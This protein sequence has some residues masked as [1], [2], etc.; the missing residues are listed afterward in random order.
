MDN[1]D[2]GTSSLCKVQAGGG[3]HLQELKPRSPFILNKELFINTEGERVLVVALTIASRIVIFF[4]SALSLDLCSALVFEAN[5]LITYLFFATPCLKPDETGFV[6]DC[7]RFNFRTFECV[8]LAKVLSEFDSVRLQ[9][10]R[11]TSYSG[12]S[13]Q[14]PGEV[15]LRNMERVGIIISKYERLSALLNK[16]R[17]LWCRRGGPF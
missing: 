1:A 15:C 2:W 5:T 12:L 3:R 13:V 14:T 16:L 7:W 8:R 6:Y 4:I 9:K 17:F 10:A 11:R